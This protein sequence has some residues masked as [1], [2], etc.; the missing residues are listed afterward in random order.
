MITIEARTFDEALDAI[1]IDEA[2]EE[3]VNRCSKYIHIEWG[4]N[5]PYD[6]KGCEDYEWIPYGEE[7]ISLEDIGVGIEELLCY[8]NELE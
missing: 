1:D 4:L 8:I 3:A 2:I 6:Y 5:K 7:T